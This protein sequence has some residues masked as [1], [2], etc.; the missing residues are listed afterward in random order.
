MTARDNP[1]LRRF[2]CVVQV[3]PDKLEYYKA[4]HASPWPEVNAILQ[5]CGIRNFSIYCKNGFLFSY[6][7][8]SGDDYEADQKK[9]AAHPKMQAWWQE[10]APC[11]M[12]LPGEPAG[13]LWSE[14]EEIYHL[15]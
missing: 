6:F 13:I 9:M 15:N 14:M 12:P 3:R 7:E 4:L 11:Q 10:T 1:V 5:A 8:Y 2:G